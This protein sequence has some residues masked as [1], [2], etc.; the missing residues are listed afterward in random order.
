MKERRSFTY[1]VYSLQFAYTLLRYLT[2]GKVIVRRKIHPK[3]K[4]IFPLCGKAGRRP[5]C[6]IFFET[7]NQGST[8]NGTIAIDFAVICKI[9]LF[10]LRHLIRQRFCHK[11]YTIILNSQRYLVA[12]NIVVAGFTN[13]HEPFDRLRSNVIFRVSFVMNLRRLCSTVNA[14]PV[15]TS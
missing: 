7:N 14:A 4:N 8:L 9:V 6:E 11:Y 13:R 10:N 2:Q 3:E 12:V 15:I 5:V 1:T